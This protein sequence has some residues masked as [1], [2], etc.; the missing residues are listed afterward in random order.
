[1]IFYALAKQL[2]TVKMQEAGTLLGESGE[3]GFGDRLLQHHQRRKKRSREYCPNI[4]R[5][6]LFLNDRYCPRGECP[7]GNTCLGM[8]G[9]SCSMCWDYWFICDDC[10]FHR[11]CYDHDLCCSRGLFFSIYVMG[12]SHTS[13]FRLWMDMIARSSATQIRV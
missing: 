3:S 9:P 6:F 2:A 7:V 13:R 8:C 10:C 1:M 11:G 5:G 12:L 4:P